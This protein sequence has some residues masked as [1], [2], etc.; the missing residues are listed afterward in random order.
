M[1]LSC[2]RQCAILC[3]ILKNS[4]ALVYL[5]INSI[6]SCDDDSYAAKLQEFIDLCP[7]LDHLKLDIFFQSNTISVFELNAPNLHSLEFHGPF[8][9]LQIKDAPAITTA[10]LSRH[11]CHW[12]IDFRNLTILLGSFS[13]V[14]CLR[15]LGYPSPV[16]YLYI[17]KF[18][19]LNF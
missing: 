4:P 5:A 6:L 3:C 14:S 8:A 18:S 7:L 11:F 15:L 13:N 17:K 12:S 19:V 1:D 2:P 9:Y 10:S 16:N